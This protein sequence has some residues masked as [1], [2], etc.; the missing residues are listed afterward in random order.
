MSSTRHCSPRIKK[1][2]NTERTSS[3]P[4]L[5]SSKE[6]KNGKS[7]KSSRSVTSAE[8]KG[9]NTWSDGRATLWPTTNGF[10]RRTWPLT[11]S[12]RST[13][14]RTDPTKRSAHLGL[15]E[16]GLGQQRWTLIVR[17]SHLPG[18]P[19]WNPRTR[20]SWQHGLG[21]RRHTGRN[22]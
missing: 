13:S 7:N 21:P 16:N 5:T 10:T 11:I 4:L 9:Y 3:N 18:K 6:K 20:T 8:E 17:T 2:W 14:G 19:L 12:S 1:Q 15:V 22:P